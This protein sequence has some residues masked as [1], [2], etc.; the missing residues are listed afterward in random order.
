[1]V[2]SRC[3]TLGYDELMQDIC[4]ILIVQDAY[5]VFDKQDAYTSLSDNNM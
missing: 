1:M 2:L 5:T 3:A 4:C